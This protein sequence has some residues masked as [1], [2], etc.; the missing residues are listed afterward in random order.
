MKLTSTITITQLER[1]EKKH[2]LAL[3][4]NEDKELS[5]NRASYNIIQEDAEL[6][7]IITASD[8]V[9]LRAVLNSI[10]KTLAIYDKT[11]ELTKN[12]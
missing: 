6:Q 7:F 10:G 5:N 4:A 9:A 1:E 3:F 11:K 12:E 8:A 2:F